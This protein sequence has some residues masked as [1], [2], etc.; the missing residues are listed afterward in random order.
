MVKKPLI[1]TSLALLGAVAVFSGLLR[2]EERMVERYTGLRFSGLYASSYDGVRL[3]DS[4]YT[5]EVEDYNGNGLWDAVFVEVRRGKGIY[6]LSFHD[7]RDRRGAVVL[8]TFAGG[9]VKV[10]ASKEELGISDGPLDSLFLLSKDLSEED[11]QRVRRVIEMMR[12]ASRRAEKKI[13]EA[14]GKRP[15]F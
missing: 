12:R 4:L 2:R 15:V 7:T 1:Y 14:L 13:H 10:V 6:T 8:T 11:L 5:V 9:G 3:R